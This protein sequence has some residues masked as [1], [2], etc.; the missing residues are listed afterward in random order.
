MKIIKIT[1]DNTQLLVEK[2]SEIIRNNGV[3]ILPFDTVY[4]YACNPKSDAALQK[5][6]ELKK[7]DLEK[8][9]GLATSE[10]K[11]IQKISQLDIN[12]EK[13]IKDRIPGRYTFIVKTKKDISISKLCFKNDTIGVRVPESK[14]ISDIIQS[15]DGIIAQT[16]ANKSGLLDCY[17]VNEL[18]AQYSE[19]ELNQV[20]LIVDGG[21]IEKN[22]PS[23]IFDL[24]SK[25]SVEI[26][27]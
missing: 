14:L 21:E 9:I 20:D 8:T 13:Y 6:F 24:T 27:R 5:I 1:K 2:V 26:K 22:N 4:G 10:I 3:V 23:R 15:S 18:R 16:S 17:S 25:E 11:D 7:R 12:T 19:N